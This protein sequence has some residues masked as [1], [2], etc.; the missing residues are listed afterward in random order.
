MNSLGTLDQFVIAKE[1]FKPVDAVAESWPKLK[2]QREM[3]DRNGIE[4][5]SETTAVPLNL[6]NSVETTVVTPVPIPTEFQSLVEVQS[7]LETTQ[8]TYEEKINE[9]AQSDDD[10]EELMTDDDD[11]NIEIKPATAKEK[12]IEKDDIDT[13]VNQVLVKKDIERPMTKDWFWISKKGVWLKDW[14]IAIPE[15][16]T[17][18]TESASDMIRSNILWDAIERAVTYNPENKAP[19]ETLDKWR[20]DQRD[21]KKHVVKHWLKSTQKVER[22]QRT[23]AP[24]KRYVPDPGPSRKQRIAYIYAKS[25][26]HVPDPGPTRKQR[27]AYIYA[28]SV[29]DN[30][31]VKPV[32]ERQDTQSYV[33]RDSYAYGK[34]FPW[35]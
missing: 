12:A 14:Y 35:S 25:K 30:G 4:K 9:I 7:P 28:K 26:N 2:L 11:V 5:L 1:L 20:V 17:L 27:I 19:T 29:S 18:W 15:T 8:P 3:P 24:P 10:E 32:P 31:Y 13:L 22:S 34:S 33:R 6:D 16:S 23:R 21:M